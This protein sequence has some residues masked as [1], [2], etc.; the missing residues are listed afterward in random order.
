MNKLQPII[1]STE[2]ANT[3]WYIGWHNSAYCA[4]KCRTKLQLSVQTFE[5]SGITLLLALILEHLDSGPSPF[6]LLGKLCFLYLPKVKNVPKSF[7]ERAQSLRSIRGG[8]NT[9]PLLRVDN[10]MSMERLGQVI[11][12][13]TIRTTRTIKSQSQGS[14][15]EHVNQVVMQFH[16]YLQSIVN[17]PSK[18]GYWYPPITEQSRSLS[19]SPDCML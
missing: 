19:C 17:D 18:D 11:E 6:L 5:G 10:E 1:G 2:C 14:A 8:V 15:E 16:D 7:P 12:P 9:H 13:L 4:Y 3:H